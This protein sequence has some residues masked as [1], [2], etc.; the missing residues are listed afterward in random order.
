MS[1]PGFDPD[2]GMHEEWMKP[3]RAG[4]MRGYDD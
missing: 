1:F 4:L 2:A 3:G